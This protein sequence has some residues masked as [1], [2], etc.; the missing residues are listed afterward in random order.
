MAGSASQREGTRS[1][2][3]LKGCEHHEATFA[4]LLDATSLIQMRRR[5]SRAGRG[6]GGGG[7][8]RLAVT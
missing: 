1:K 4:V 8:G 6:S 5:G 3:V 2:E 7:G